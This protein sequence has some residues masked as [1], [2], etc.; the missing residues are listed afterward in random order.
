MPG[1]SFLYCTQPTGKHTRPSPC[2]THSDV[3]KPSSPDK[4]T[5]PK[6]LRP[7]RETRQAEASKALS[8]PVSGPGSVATA[9]AV[10]VIGRPL[11]NGALVRDPYSRQK[12]HNPTSH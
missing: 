11:P 5:W 3:A 7:L 10:V 4:E 2:Q 12:D 9:N 8:E 6:I 1:N